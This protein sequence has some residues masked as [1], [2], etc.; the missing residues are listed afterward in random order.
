M[1]ELLETLFPNVMASPDKFIKSVQETRIMTGWA[2][3]FMFVIGLALGVLL[4]VTRP[5]GIAQNRVL[6][7]VLDKV[8]NMLRSIPFVILI[9]LLISLSGC[10]GIENALHE[11]GEKI[12]SN[13]VETPQNNGGDIDWSFVPVVRE[14]AVSLFT[15]AF[16]DATVKETG[17]ACKNTKADRVI[18]TISYE[19]NGKNGDYGFDYEKDENGEYVLKRYGGGVSSDDL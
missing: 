2:G 13:Q 15:E 6:Y 1:Q 10:T 18:V 5:G 12:Q 11:A 4:V 8:I 9:A 7:Q 19:L 3:A 17:V 16:P 14:K